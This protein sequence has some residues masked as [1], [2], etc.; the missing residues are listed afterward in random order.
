MSLWNTSLVTPKLWFREILP[1]GL[2]AASTA[3][4]DLYTTLGHQNLTVPTPPLQTNTPGTYSA[5]TSLSYY[6]SY[7]QGYPPANSLTTPVRDPLCLIIHCIVSEYSPFYSAP[8]RT[9]T[10]DTP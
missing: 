7:K 9:L 4:M 6:E 8:D 3:N 1:V 10:S 5:H 2:R